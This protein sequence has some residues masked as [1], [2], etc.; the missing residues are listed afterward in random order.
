MRIEVR[1]FATLRRC[2]PEH[3][4][5]R[6]LLELP[7]GATVGEAADRLGVARAEIHL[8]MVNGIGVD[9]ERR[10]TEGDRLGLFPPVGG[11]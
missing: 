2:T 7:E 5:G 4:D 11:G 1:L 8:A 10:M 3:P 6:Q 9:L